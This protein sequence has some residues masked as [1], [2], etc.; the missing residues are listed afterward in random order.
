MPTRHFTPIDIFFLERE[1]SINY[2][3][4]KLIKE[5]Y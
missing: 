5:K 4:Y 2:L 1:F 3:I